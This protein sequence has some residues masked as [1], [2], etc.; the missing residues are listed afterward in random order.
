[1]IN[2]QATDYRQIISGFIEAFKDQRGYQ[3]RMSEAVGC[4]RSQF[5]R[6]LKGE[7][8]LT[9]DQ[10][11]KLLGFWGET[12][13]YA[14]IFLDLLA[15]ERAA[16]QELKLILRRRISDNQKKILKV[17]HHLSKNTKK[18][19]FPKE[20]FGDWYYSAIHIL[21][22][23]GQT[24]TISEVA[25]YLDLTES[26]CSHAIDTLMQANLIEKAETGWIALG[27][28]FHIARNSC[29]DRQ[30]H[31]NWRLKSINKIFPVDEQACHY[32]SVVGLSKENALLLRDR[33]IEFIA[34]TRSINEH[35]PDEEIY[36]FCLDYFPLRAKHGPVDAPI[37]RKRVT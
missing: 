12:G 6:I 20:Y 30:H 7:L 18:G 19:S 22:M 26:L 32:T 15:L 29:D 17:E 11:A 33:I 1:M 10:G 23:T 14:E 5:S 35:D 34:D 3:S 24:K 8:D 37:A 36:S 25:Q 21:I 13:T 28:D 9:M 4:Q 27:T 2:W 31:K 16:T